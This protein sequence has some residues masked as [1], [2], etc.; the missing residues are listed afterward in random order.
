MCVIRGYSNNFVTSAAL[1][2]VCALLSAILVV[3]CFICRDSSYEEQRHLHYS[4]EK[5][6]RLRMTST[7][8]GRTGEISNHSDAVMLV[9]IRSG[10]SNLL[11]PLFG[12]STPQYIS[13]S[14]LITIFQVDLG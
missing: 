13:L 7:V 10:H 9:Q 12:L 8:S 2:E 3:F 1:V 11:I 5:S 4:R 6:Q 14:G